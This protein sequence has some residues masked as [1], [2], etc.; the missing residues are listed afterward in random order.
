[1]SL[2]LRCGCPALGVV[3]TCYGPVPL[4]GFQP[5][6]APV[7]RVGRSSVSKPRSFEHS[8]SPSR[9]NGA[10]PFGVTIADASKEASASPGVCSPVSPR[11]ELAHQ[12]GR[13]RP[14]GGS[15]PCS[16]GQAARLRVAPVPRKRAPLACPCQPGQ[17]GLTTGRHRGTDTS[18]SGA[19]LQNTAKR[20]YS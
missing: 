16:P 11:R 12:A 4:S 13:G 9:H 17:E 5:F 7:S 3:P 6:P 10:R 19:L 1:M 14:K 8:F 18:P 20:Q 15:S 2:C